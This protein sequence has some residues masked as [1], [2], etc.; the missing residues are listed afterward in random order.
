V[1]T[2]LHPNDVIAGSAPAGIT[3]VAVGVDGY[4]EGNDAA[5]LGADLARLSKANLLLV[6]VHADP[7]VVLPKGMDWRSLQQH[8]KATLEQARASLAPG[9]RLDVETDFSVPRA[10]RRVVR[11]EH[12][13]LLVLGS[14]RLGPP[15][16]VRIG[17]RTRQLLCGFECSLAVAPRGFHR[18]EDPRLRRIGVGHDGGP[19]AGAALALAAALALRCGA[20]LHVLGVVDDRIRA[21]GWSRIGTA[22]AI[23]PG[24]GWEAIGSAGSTPGWDDAVRTSEQ[25][26]RASLESATR[27]TGAAVGSLEVIRGRP[28]NALLA[29]GRSSD[30]LVIGSRR[31]GLVARL[32]L[33][34]TGEAVLHDAECPVLI[35]PR[36]VDPGEEERAGAT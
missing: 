30:L 21:L 13:D 29:L 22:P 14:S 4:P 24:L 10:L 20:E 11:R 3:R 36:P 8:A 5:A 27:A 35:V 31:W 26:L 23:I 7:L 18:R 25:S 15:D 32:V 34:S 16:R 2:A 19:E 9:A 6:A 28:A 17:K 12:R 33:G 1:D